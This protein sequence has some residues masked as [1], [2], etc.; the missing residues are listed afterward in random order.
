MPPTT[1]ISD[2]WNAPGSDVHFQNE[3]GL[4][5]GG[6]A[7]A[8]EF[9]RQLGFDSGYARAVADQLEFSVAAAEQV[10][11]EHADFA[12]GPID[13]RRLLYAFIEIMDRRLDLFA[14]VAASR[15]DA[16]YMEGGLGI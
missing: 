3:R 12:H 14:N 1:D 10:L 16:H 6:F 9:Y 13:P 2:L 15:C 4:V 7:E 11:R 5:T 8:A